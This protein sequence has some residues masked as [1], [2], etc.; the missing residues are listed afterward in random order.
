MPVEIESILSPV[1]MGERKHALTDEE[2]RSFEERE[3]EKK[4]IKIK[5]LQTH[6]G[7]PDGIRIE[8]YQTG[9]VY[10]LPQRLARIFLNEGWGIELRA[11]NKQGE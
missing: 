2:K 3:K 9:Q 8:E 1:V 6:K 10:D 11:E 7:S 4:P 5:M